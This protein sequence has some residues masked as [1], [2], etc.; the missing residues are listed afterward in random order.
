MA[1]RTTAK[2]KSKESKPG[3]LHSGSILIGMGLGVA[4]LWGFQAWQKATAARAALVRP[5][6]APRLIQPIQQNMV[7]MI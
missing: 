1:T 5:V 2:P 7:K 6:V 4:L 3:Q